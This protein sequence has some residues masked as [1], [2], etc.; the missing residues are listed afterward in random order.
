MSDICNE[1][2]ESSVEELHHN[3]IIQNLTIEKEVLA[4]LFAETFLKYQNLKDA[5]DCCSASNT[6]LAKRLW[7]IKTLFYEHSDSIRIPKELKVEIL[8]LLEF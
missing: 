6:D 5:F 7:R 3:D 8:D 2:K 1:V 4:K